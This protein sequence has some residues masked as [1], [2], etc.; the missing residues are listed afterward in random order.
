MAYRVIAEKSWI[1]IQF[2]A[3]EAIMAK[4]PDV[5]DK[6]ILVD[7]AKLGADVAKDLTYGPTGYDPVGVT[8]LSKAIVD[9]TESSPGKV[10]GTFDLTATG[11]AEI[12]DPTTVKALGEKAK[13]IPFTATVTDGKVTEATYSIPAVGGK[14]AYTATATLTKYGE[15]PAITA[16]SAAEST[17]ATDAI[18]EL[19]RG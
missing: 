11:E 2:E 6:W 16:P 19:L 14:K 17:E 5:P 7:P 15:I 13:S 3:S 18:Y 12:V 9:A 4:L 1:K 10:T 8:A